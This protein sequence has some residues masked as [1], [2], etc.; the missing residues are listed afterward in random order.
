[1]CTSANYPWWQY[2]A[3]KL[4]S[5]VFMYKLP[6][7]PFSCKVAVGE[8]HTLRQVLQDPLTEK[9][10]IIYETFRRV[11]GG[12]GVAPTVF[13]SNGEVWHSKRKAVAAAFSSNHVKRMT[14]LAMEFTDS[15]IDNT[16]S[17]SFSINSNVSGSF[18]VAKEMVSIT[19]SAI[20]KTAFEYEITSEEKE[21]LAVDLEVALIEFTRKEPLS[22][23]RRYIGLL[24]PRRRHA[25]AA[26]QRVRGLMMKII[27]MCR[28]L[29]KPTPG[30][31]INLVMES[32]SFPSDEERAAQ[33]AEF[34]L[35][36]HDTTAY[37]IAWI[38]LELARNPLEQKQLRE[39][40]SSLTP[41]E[42]NSSEKLKM[43]IK[44]GMRLHPVAASGSLRK[45]GRDIT[46]PNNELIPKGSLCF[47][48][49]ILLFRNPDIF[50]IPNKFKPN[51]WKNPTRDMLDAF[52]PFSLG[53]QNCVGQ[54]LAKA[55]TQ[56]IVARIC[57]EFEMIVEDEG[58]VDFFLTLKPVG[59]QLRVC[60]VV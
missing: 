4:N 41:E 29:E 15:W 11:Y 37:S 60:K 23:W 40:L 12:E 35:A 43:V 8:L 54:S 24:L 36:G 44:E 34:L 2:I 13:T 14:K 38:L 31:V 20:T 30:T 57:S 48:P 55:E 21:Q 6:V 53:K 5:R 52:N 27:E 32:D 16:L 39:E 50:P 10:P 9:P 1:M 33:L 19:I 28:K 17:A 58:D 42:W 26:S 46:T 3:E 25:F 22:K 51:R 18:D 7:E 49:F 45:T 56:A 47:C 59:A